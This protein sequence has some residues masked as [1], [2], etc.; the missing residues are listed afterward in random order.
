M[1]I[2]RGGRTDLIA[3]TVLAVLACDWANDEWE[4]FKLLQVLH[5]TLFLRHYFVR[6]L[7]LL[8]LLLLSVRRMTE[9]QSES[10]AKYSSFTASHVEF[11]HA[12]S[13]LRA[14]HACR[15]PRLL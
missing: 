4:P 6:S 3:P 14:P 11:G 8:L 12:L 7:L 15:L 10:D 9:H 5:I 1:F 2:V 13:P